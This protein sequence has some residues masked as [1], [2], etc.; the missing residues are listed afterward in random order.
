MAKYR[1][2]I[3]DLEIKRHQSSTRADCVKCK[4]CI[5][6]FGGAADADA[7]SVVI[8]DLGDVEKRK[9]KRDGAAIGLF[10][11]TISKLT[12]QHS[13]KDLLGE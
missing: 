5:V 4:C 11:D 13:I 3:I 2:Y 1:A 7:V 9:K 6:L 10:V 8:S 12:E